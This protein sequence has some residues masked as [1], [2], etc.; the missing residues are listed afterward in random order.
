[1]EES[2]TYQA[3]VRKGR[4][5]GV[6]KLLLRMGTIQFGRP[7]KAVRD[8]LETITDPE[9]LDQLGERLLRVASWEE[10]LDLPSAARK[11][12]RRKTRE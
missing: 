9:R 11:P 1:M 12:R 10:L 7:T 8:A 4:L 5:Q 3:I 6:R 2:V